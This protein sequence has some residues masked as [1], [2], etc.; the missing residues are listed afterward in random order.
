MADIARLIDRAR[1]TTTED[2][3]GLQNLV[4]ELVGELLTVD[5]P[6][7]SPLDGFS[8]DYRQAIA[9]SPKGKPIAI[10]KTWTTGPWRCVLLDYPSV[11]MGRPM[12]VA[13]RRIAAPANKPLAR[14]DV[15]V[16]TPWKTQKAME[17]IVAA[18]RALEITGPTGEIALHCVFGLRP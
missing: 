10:A 12:F 11:P 16:R 14:A 6:P 17:R 8:T 2:P 4:Y 3:E 13:R 1:E 5:G 9:R 15:L 18:C 7:V